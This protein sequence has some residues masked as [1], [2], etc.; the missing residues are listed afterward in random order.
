LA[1]RLTGGG[2]IPSLVELLWLAYMAT[3]RQRLGYD[4]AEVIPRAPVQ[5]ERLL[6]RFTGIEN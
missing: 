3:V 4:V 1:E 6:W 2:H 5:S